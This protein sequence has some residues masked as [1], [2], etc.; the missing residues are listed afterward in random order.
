[1]DKRKRDQLIPERNKP[2]LGEQSDAAVSRSGGAEGGHVEEMSQR[3][4]DFAGTRRK[5]LSLDNT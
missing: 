1:M 2:F 3:W 5:Q 4:R